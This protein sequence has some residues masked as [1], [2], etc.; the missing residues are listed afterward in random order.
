MAKIIHKNNRRYRIQ[1]S[2]NRDLYETYQDIIARAGELE[3][4]VGFADDFERWFADQLVQ[5]GRLLEE[6]EKNSKSSRNESE[7]HIELSDSK[8][9]HNHSS[10]DMPAEEV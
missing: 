5:V 4:V 10:I 1:F 9:G 8:F 6:Y 3:A 7:T 2:M